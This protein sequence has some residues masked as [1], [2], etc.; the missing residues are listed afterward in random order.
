MILHTHVDCNRKL[1]IEENV[2]ICFQLHEKMGAGLSTFILNKLEVDK[3]DF[4]D[5]RRQGFDNG[6]NMA[7][8]KYKGEYILE[9]INL[10]IFVPN[11][12]VAGAHIA[13]TTSKIIT[14][15]LYFCSDY[16][17][18][19][20]SSTPHWNILMKCPELSLKSFSDAKQSQRP[21]Q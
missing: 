19:F 2:I 3:L 18:F 6:V 8:G 13:S 17:I 12:N 20:L 5:C 21:V 1:I 9:I 16:Y 4:Q 10:A 15:F 14:F 11:L 7:A